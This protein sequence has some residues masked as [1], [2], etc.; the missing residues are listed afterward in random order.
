MKEKLIKTIKALGDAGSL[1]DLKE[2][3]ITVLDNDTFEVDVECE[4]K[5]DTLTDL[6]E[7]LDDI[8]LALALSDMFGDI[9]HAIADKEDEYIEKINAASENASKKAGYKTAV[10]IVNM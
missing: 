6:A 8:Y 1:K 10:K 5:K 4:S 3:K 9:M 2:L 7:V